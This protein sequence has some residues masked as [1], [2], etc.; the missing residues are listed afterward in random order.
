ML[1]AKILTKISEEMSQNSM[2][3][4]LSQLL[5]KEELNKLAQET[6]FTTRKS[7]KLLGEH[8]FDLQVNYLSNSPKQEQSLS[9]MCD[10][11]EEKYGIKMNKGS[12]DARY[13]PS[14]EA[15]LQKCLEKL[16]VSFTE[17]IS[18]S[19]PIPTAF[20]GIEISDCIGFEL[21]SQLRAHYNKSKEG[22]S[23]K[24]HLKIHYSF[25]LLHPSKQ[26][27]QIKAG[28]C[29]D[30]DMWE[31][32]TLRP[33][34]LYL[35]DLGFFSLSQ[36]QK[37]DKAK[38]YFLSRYKTG[39]HLAIKD[40]DG[41]LVKLDLA[42]VL[43]EN[44]EASYYLPEVYIGKKEKLKVRLVIVK[45]PDELK[46]KR[47]KELTAQYKTRKGNRKKAPQVSELKM[48]L[49]GYNLFITNAEEATLPTAQIALVYSL[50]W[51]IE[52]LFKIW[53]SLFQIDKLPKMD[54]SRFHCFLYGKLI[55]LVLC[56]SL[57]AI[58]KTQIAQNTP[59]M[60]ELSEW[61][62]MKTLKKKWVNS[63]NF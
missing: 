38:A 25:D 44:K 47:I 39:T 26:A 21:P 1:E 27:I 63:S 32:S 33:G 50:R 14:A 53:K 59:Q 29:A 57:T 56:S 35:Q 52:L 22:L 34:T 40:E 18:K 36:Y 49:C 9:D 5:N 43:A 3:E 19:T 48:L 13:T 20:A 37:I 45:L 62:V 11:L 10:Y 55:A 31:H 61:K 58:L 42:T 28:H 15:F 41:V 46:A 6:K 23:A 24:S 2:V 51:Q 7:A 12:L 4:K 8:F 16:L 17:N 54:I 30:V 60:I